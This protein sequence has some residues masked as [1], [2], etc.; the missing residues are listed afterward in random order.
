MWRGPLRNP[1]LSKIKVLERLEIQ[2]NII[3]EV[4]SKPTANI[5]LND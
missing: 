5:N 1:M 4:N 3:K 2:C